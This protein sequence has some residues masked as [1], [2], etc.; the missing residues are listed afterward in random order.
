MAA[1][2]ATPDSRFAEL[3]PPMSREEALVEADRC[4]E[5]GGLSAP[6]PC[7]TA[8]PAGVDIPSFVTAL[9]RGDPDS[10]A[11]T[12][13]AE[14][15]LGG[16]CA[17][18]CPVEVLCEGACVLVHEH[19][20]PIEIGR[21]QR[22]AADS[23]L[24]RGPA[25]RR[26]APRKLQR[27]AVVGAG[28]A[29]L[30]C[31]GELAARGYSVTI[32]DERLEPGG[33]VRFGIAPYRQQR[34]PLPAEAQLIAKLGVSFE[35]GIAL[36][37]LDALAQLEL[38]YDAIVLAVGMGGDA[39]VRYPGDE[40]GGVWD[41]LPF[42]EA[43][44]TG[45]APQVGSAVAVAG[46]GNTAIDV[47]REAVRLGA[48]DVTLVYR[49]TQAEMPAYPHEVE[50]AREEGVQFE[51][52][53]LPVRFLGDA[54]LRAVECRRM[55]LGEPDASGRRRPVE[56]PGTEFVLPVDTVV[57]AIGQRPR[58]AFLQSVEG[59]ELEAGRPVFD[60]ATGQTGNPKFF[61]AGDVTNG[62]ATVVE[63]VREA[64]LAARGVD[65]WLSE[66]TL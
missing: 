5:C 8:C 21:L 49:R 59:L 61:V 29:G 18:V 66:A 42:I 35:L 65:E 4:L 27:I 11:R 2:A 64:K 15:L 48:S 36:D 43:I 22:F 54:R 51:W 33:L 10:A 63:A 1:T 37:T 41:S 50:E 31:A 32:F 56:M 40:L 30:A 7:V 34:E 62:G 12:I 39:D 20:R 58:T 9:A 60:P 53:T 52:L 28:P 57:K 24:A 38:S 55:R 44:K 16:T 6:A 17:R 23:A 46:G 3:R 26:R 25:L 47:A 45:H 19:R 13:F 14:N